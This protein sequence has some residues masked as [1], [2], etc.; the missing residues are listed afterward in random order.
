M[1]LPL[2]FGAISALGTLSAGRAAARQ[3][4]NQAKQMEIENI[5][6]Q[7]QAVQEQNLLK[8]QYEAASNVNDAMFSFQEGE[9]TMN[10]A[11]FEEAQ[12]DA[13]GSNIA[14]MQTQAS[15]EKSSRTV[16][17]LNQYEKASNTRRA[18]LFKA[19]GTMGNAYMDFKAL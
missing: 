9:K 7:A 11:A 3:Q 6:S 10:V 18:A 14:M 2:I 15:L 17:S 13:F 8:L 1:A 4:E 12:A 19:I 16:A 5:I